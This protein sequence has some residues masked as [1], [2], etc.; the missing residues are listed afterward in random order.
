MSEK[1]KTVTSPWPHFVTFSVHSWIDVF[2]RNHYRNIFVDSLNYCIENKGLVVHAWVLMTNHTHLLIN[3]R[4][5]DL[6][7]VVRD[8][9]KFTSKAI[10]RALEEN[11]QESRKWIVR[12]L[13]IA[14]KNNVMNEEYQFWQNG[15]HPIHCWSKELIR[16]KMEYIH[17]N[18]LRAGQ[19]GHDYEWLH[20]SAGD[21]ATRVGLVKIEKLEYW[22]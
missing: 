5:G 9:K 13:A 10:V 7:G 12:F 21:Y 16:Q 1:Y 18:P 4:Q 22:R 14:G 2:T 19:V 8:F 15:Y 11:P 20:R 3:V 17:Q 6:P